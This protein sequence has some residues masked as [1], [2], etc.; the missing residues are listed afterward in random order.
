MTKEAQPG[1]NVKRVANMKERWQD[2][3][4]RAWKIA[5]QVGREVS[6]ATREKI[7][8]KRMGQHHSKENKRKM[9]LEKGGNKVEIYIL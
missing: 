8:K 7:S 4:Y 5:L 2:A 9:S 3:E 1:K 6:P